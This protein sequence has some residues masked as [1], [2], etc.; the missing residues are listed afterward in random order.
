MSGKQVRDKSTPPRGC[1]HL[2]GKTS[3]R[4]R[5]QT[6]PGRQ[7][8][9]MLPPQGTLPGPSSR[10]TTAPPRCANP[11]QGHLSPAALFRD[12]LST[13]IIAPSGFIVPLCA[14]ATRPLTLST[15]QETGPRASVSAALASTLWRITTDPRGAAV[16]A[17][18][19]TTCAGAASGLPTLRWP[20]RSPPCP[21]PSS[22][23]LLKLA[24]SCSR[25]TARPTGAAKCAASTSE[26]CPRW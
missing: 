9:D 6:I 4:C 3:Q 17:C 19:P 16:T 12:A 8:I 23:A 2:A 1:Q 26:S 14:S 11:N 13:G 15:F 7:L 21:S 18:Q 10:Q 24:A 25:P 20:S 22:T 5:Q